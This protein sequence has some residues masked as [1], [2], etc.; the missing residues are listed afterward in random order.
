MQLLL[1]SAIL[2][3]GTAGGTTAGIMTC[4]PSRNRNKVVLN[5]LQLLCRWGG[6]P[7]Y[8]FEKLDKADQALLDAEIGKTNLGK[9]IAAAGA[10]ESHQ[11]ASHKLLHMRVDSDFLT[12]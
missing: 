10:P 4:T 3:G 2:V 7:R 8:I 1:L 12:T 9:L 6:V 11:S 5:L